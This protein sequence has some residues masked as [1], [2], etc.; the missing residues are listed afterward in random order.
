MVPKAEKERKNV[1]SG[2][3]QASDVVLPLAISNFQ[4]AAGA[5]R[6]APVCVS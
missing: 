1:I 2:S 5:P 6:F 3:L 4:P